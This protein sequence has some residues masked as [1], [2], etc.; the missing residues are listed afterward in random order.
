M[1][2]YFSSCTTFK[3]SFLLKIFFFKFKFSKK[4]IFLQL[5]LLSKMCLFFSWIYNIFVWKRYK[6][7]KPLQNAK[8]CILIIWKL[9]KC[10]KSREC[11]ELFD[12]KLFTHGLPNEHKWVL[13]IL[14]EYFRNFHVKWMW[15]ISVLVSLNL[16]V[17][18]KIFVQPFGL[19][20]YRIFVITICFD[21]KSII[22]SKFIFSKKKKNKY[23]LRHYQN[24]VEITWDTHPPPRKRGKQRFPATSVAHGIF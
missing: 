7:L 2:F 4:E 12:E 9:L 13:N 1:E 23:R 19:F 18:Q 21:Q 11:Y 6:S 8:S 24:N 5:I 14:T 15:K 3:H 16:K 22:W 17:C 20:I 10:I